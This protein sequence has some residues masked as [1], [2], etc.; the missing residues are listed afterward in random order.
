MAFYTAQGLSQQ[1]TQ[2]QFQLRRPLD[3]ATQQQF[4]EK[5]NSDS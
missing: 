4:K 5:C 2:L 1:V 3:R